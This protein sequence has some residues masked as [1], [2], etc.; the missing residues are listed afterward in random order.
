MTFEVLKLPIS[1]N[2]NKEQPSNILFISVTIEVLKVV[3][4][5]E[6]NDLQPVN[7]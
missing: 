7:I 1:I 5:I 2:F 6:V 4:S 3:T